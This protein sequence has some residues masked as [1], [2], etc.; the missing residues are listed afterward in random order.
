MVK[1]YRNGWWLEEKYRTEGLTQNEIAQEC[2]VSPRTIRRYM[3]KFDIDARSIDG[4]NHP[5]YGKNR[6]EETKQKIAQTLTGRH[7][8]PQGRRNISNSL[9]GRRLPESRGEDCIVPRGS[10]TAAGDQETDE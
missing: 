1:R 9:T 5:L 10:R 8:D 2:E 7:L 4:E 6:S 3:Q